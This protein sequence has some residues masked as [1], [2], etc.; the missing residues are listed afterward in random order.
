MSAGRLVV[1]GQLLADHVANG[2]A[3]AAA[4]CVARGGGIVLSRGY[5]R[6]RPDAGAPAVTTDTPFLIASVTKPFVA[7]SV[8]LLVERGQVALSDPVKLYI[9]EF[10]GGRRDDVLVRHLLTHASG[11]PDMTADNIPL[12]QRNAPMSEFIRG[13]VKDKLVFAP[14]GDVRYQS[15]GFALQGELIERVAK[16]PLREFMR[17]EIFEPLGLKNTA[18][19][20]GHITLEDSP[21]VDVDD[22]IAKADTPPNRKRWDHNSPY[23]R[24]LGAAWGGMHSSVT[25]T[26][27]FYRM[28]LD[29]GVC[30]GGRVI[31]RA[32][33]A[34]MTQNQN[35][36]PLKPWGLGFGIGAT[37]MW[38][39]FGDLAGPRTFGHG[40]ATGCVAWADP[41]A[42]LLCV[43][44]TTRPMSR[45]GG[46]FLR[47]VS[48]AVMAAVGG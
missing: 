33:V 25:D 44:H 11:L 21:A 28:L 16:Q 47:C 30:A 18:L 23:W 36:P 3:W 22:W 35:P 37:N 19:G 10:T 39:F 9:P 41:D 6:L 27:V 8:M 13:I 43:I 17:R 34:A 26:A 42:D 40:G 24:D 7:L 12:R 1:A 20:L 32:T 14:G 29:G 31:G 5:G 4:I 46:R 38:G 2:Q 45:D 48:N 15:C